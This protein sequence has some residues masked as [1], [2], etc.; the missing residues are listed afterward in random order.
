MRVPQ[1]AL[2]QEVLRERKRVYQT[3]QD[4]VGE[5]SV[6]QVGE[7]RHGRTRQGRRRGRRGHAR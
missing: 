2:G 3:L 6:A 1:V 4:R 5:A 7:A